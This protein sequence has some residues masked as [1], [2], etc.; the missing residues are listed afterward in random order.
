MGE[1]PGHTNGRKTWSPFEDSKG[2]SILKWLH[3]TDP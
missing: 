3:P 1:V 2:T